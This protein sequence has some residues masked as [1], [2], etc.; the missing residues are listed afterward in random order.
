M[1]MVDKFDNKR[2]A[3]GIV[4]ERNE[5]V[6]GEYRQAMHCWIMNDNG[7]FL[8]QKRA[9]DKD[10]YPGYWSVTGGGTDSGETTLDTVFR[11]CKEELGLT[12]D[13]EN[14]ELIMMVKRSI[15]FI[16]IYLWKANVD[17]NDV[18]MQ[19]EEVQ[20][21]KWATVSE[22]KEMIDSGEFAPNVASYMDMFMSLVKEFSSIG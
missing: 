18:V 3:L 4:R 5:R 16:D 17:L 19:V 7:Q 14:L 2:V 10:S 11:E 1:E 8:L 13:A 15:A 21:V 9:D 6:A 20:D 22:I 12:V